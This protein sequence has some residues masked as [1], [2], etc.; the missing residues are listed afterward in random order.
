MADNFVLLAKMVSG[1][2]HKK[3]SEEGRELLQRLA[4][5]YEVDLEE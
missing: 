4:E 1:R 5:V 3:L 2:E